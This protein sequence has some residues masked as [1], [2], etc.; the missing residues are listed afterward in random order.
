MYLRLLIAWS[1]RVRMNV[2]VDEPDKG[3][4]QYLNIT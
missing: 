4:M 1:E 2:C 3:N